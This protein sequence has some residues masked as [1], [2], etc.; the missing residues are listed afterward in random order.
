ME[1]AGIAL[2]L[3]ARTLSADLDDPLD[4]YPTFH[5]TV[6]VAGIAPASKRLTVKESPCSVRVLFDPANSRGRDFTGRFV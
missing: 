3:I 1:V 4:N 5:E 6:E 2:A